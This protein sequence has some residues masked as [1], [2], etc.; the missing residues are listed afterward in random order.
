LTDKAAQLR[1]AAQLAKAL[2]QPVLELQ[3]LR[4]LRQM[5]ALSYDPEPVDISGDAKRAMVATE[6]NPGT[7][8]MGR[9]FDNLLKG[10]K[11][12]T[13]QAVGASGL[14]PQATADNARSDLR[15]DREHD[16]R[17]YQPLAEE[18]PNS[19]AIAEFLGENGPFFGVPVM[20]AESLAG[21]VGRFAERTI[22]G[23][24]LR[25]SP[26][27]VVAGAQGS[28]P[29]DPEAGEASS[30]ASEAALVGGATRLAT[31]YLARRANVRRGRFTDDIQQFHDLGEEFG[32]PVRRGSLEAQLRGAQNAAEQF[33][34]GRGD[35]ILGQEAVES[36]GEGMRGRQADFRT[37]YDML[38]GSLD[39]HRVAPVS[40]RND[41]SRLHKTEKAK[42]SMADPALMA[43][44]KRWMKMPKAELSLTDLHN[45]RRDL[46]HR[47]KSQ[48]DGPRAEQWKELEDTITRRLHDSADEMAPGMGDALKNLDAWYYEDIER[49]GRLPGVRGALSENPTPANFL[50]WII[51]KPGPQKLEAFEV[52]TDSGRDAVREA[53]WNRAFRSGARGSQFSPLNYAKSIE[54]NLEAAEQFM[55]PDDF[56]AYRNLG[57]LMRHIAGEGETADNSILRLARGFPFMYRAVTDAVRRSNFRFLLAHA[58]A[59]ITPGSPE[60]DRWYR[61]IIRS[62][63]IQDS[64]TQEAFPGILKEVYD[65]AGSPGRDQA[66]AVIGRL[67]PSS[68]R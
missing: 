67:S 35:A 6:S 65:E 7:V 15:R 64:D 58:P 36:V 42:G 32:V 11:D 26:E 3:Y 53:L 25:A 10:A 28:L 57:A 8:F 66:R 18:Y 60:M 59:E 30:R 33:N 56:R 14:V 45:Y 13:L 24:P 5:G 39:Q 46:R 44:Y 21:P 31:D 2:D 41:V 61:G 29:Y 55:R 38:F 4:Q 48:A 40:I 49:I 62:L 43:E 22:L 63:A 19:S 1:R 68:S 37:S 47:M 12:L 51:T 23:A 34:T 54:A 17:A 20:R 50:N 16:D 52:L 9:G 27:A